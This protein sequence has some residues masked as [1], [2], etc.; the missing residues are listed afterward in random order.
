MAA[1]MTPEARVKALVHER[2]TI[3]R[4]LVFV[5]THPNGMVHVVGPDEDQPH[6]DND[7]SWLLTQ[8]FRTVC[9][10]TVIKPATDGLESAFDD[11][12]L[13]RHCADA[14]NNISFR[15]GA[16]IFEDNRAEVQAWARSHVAHVQ[17]RK[18]LGRTPNRPNQAKETHP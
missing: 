11:D 18:P 5:A 4:P 8:R 1:T 3:G 13:C 9:G 16:L 14:F 10:R 2:E 15:L 17:Q 12:R 6:C 7:I